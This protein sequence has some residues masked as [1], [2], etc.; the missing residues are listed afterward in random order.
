MQTLFSIKY[1]HMQCS[2]QLPLTQH[3]M[4]LGFGELIAAGLRTEPCGQL[5]MSHQLGPP[6]VSLPQ[7][8]TKIWTRDVSVSVLPPVDTVTVLSKL[9]PILP[10]AVS[11]ST[12]NAPFVTGSWHTSV[13]GS[14]VQSA[15]QKIY[16]QT[17]SCRWLILCRMPA[18]V[19]AF[20]A[21]E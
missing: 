9:P 2:H 17:S 10:L 3:T 19:V 14:S 18:S 4:E 8:G 16:K 11:V 1:R 7:V 12:G 6:G 20:S 5:L 21:S 15:K 13:V